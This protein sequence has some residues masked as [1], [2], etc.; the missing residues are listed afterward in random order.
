M[1]INASKH[2]SGWDQDLEEAASDYEI[3][4]EIGRGGMGIVFLAEQSEPVRRFVALK[5]IRPGMDTRHV[6]ERFLSER[7]VLAM[8]DHPGIAHVYDAGETAGGRP[9]FVMEWIDG[10]DLNAHSAEVKLTLRQKLALLLQICDALQYA[11]TRGVVHCDLKPS[12][13]LVPM[14]SGRAQIKVID[15]GIARAIDPEA[16]HGAAGAILT[17]GTVHVVGTPAYMAPELSS[18]D[19]LDVDTRADVYSLGAMLF[20]M[21]TG[22]APTSVG[23]QSE[24]FGAEK[25]LEDL[26]AIVH[27]AMQPDRSKR[28]TTVVQFAEDVDRFLHHQPVRAVPQTGMYIFRKFARRHRVGLTVAS[29]VALTLVSIAWVAV[30]QAVRATKAEAHANE[31]RA[32][33]QELITFMLDDLYGSLMPIGKLE[34]LDGVIGKAD[35]Y[36]LAMT[37]EEAAQPE[38]VLN[39]ASVLSKAGWMKYQQG[40]YDKAADFT[41][42]ALALVD[43]LTD[44]GLDG[45]KVKFAKA[46]YTSDLGTIIRD[47]G[48]MKEGVRLFQ[49][50]ILEIE[51]ILADGPEEPWEYKSIL[52]G[53][54]NLLGSTRLLL[55]QYEPALVE[56]TLAFVLRQQMLDRE[57]DNPERLNDVAKMHLDIGRAH[58]FLNDYKKAIEQGEKALMIREKLPIMRP[59]ERKWRARL[60]ETHHSLARFYK[61]LDGENVDKGFAHIDQA[62]SIWKTLTEEEN[63]NILWRRAYAV[64]VNQKVSICLFSERYERGLE[65][66]ETGCRLWQSILEIEPGNLVTLKEYSY[67]LCNFARICEKTDRKPQALGLY[68]QSVKANPKN[69]IAVKGLERI[70]RWLN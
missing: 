16:K 63:T 41:R 19:P 47:S 14:A 34:Y 9:Y 1:G 30:F 64:S 59:Q 2:A 50:A 4:D 54:R 70:H 11:H 49:E 10:V 37:E 5:V 27:K 22:R 51:E 53:V 43:Q 44:Y 33:S 61:R 58:E 67:A 20:E 40:E 66:G 3:I 32:E 8:M 31:L 45:A 36:F 35:G 52:A 68:E 62:I 46:R 48:D 15:F 56:L 38:N 28:Y 65:A 39:R 42:R 55:A 24:D 13:I 17:D 6:L 25:S 69:G 23:S 60:A 29:L 21:I 7:Q 12:N 57:P 18:G 26:Q